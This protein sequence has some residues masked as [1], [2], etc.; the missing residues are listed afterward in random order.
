MIPIF[1]EFI[2]HI[3]VYGIK[4]SVRDNSPLAEDDILARCF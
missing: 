3:I 1:R 2:I 4:K